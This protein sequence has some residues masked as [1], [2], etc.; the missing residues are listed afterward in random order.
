MNAPQPL[1]VRGS[2]GLHVFAAGVVT[3]Q[4]SW[5]PMALTTLVADHA[6]ITTAGLWP[7]STLLGPNLRR[8]S[9]AATAR[10]EVA[11]TIDDGPDP[12]VTPRVLDLLDTLQVRATF[13]CIGTRVLAH[14]ALAREIVQRGHA[15]ENHSHIHRHDFSLLMP[16]AYDR[17][18]G[19]AQ[20]AIAD[21]VGVAP[22]FFRAPAGLRNVF[23][24]GAL[25]RQ[26][27]TLT[28]WTRRGYDT[29][30]RDADRVA[31]R[32]VDG[33][34]AGDILLLHD[35]HAARDRAGTPVILDALPR[36]VDAIRERAL[37]PTTLRDAAR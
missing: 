18:I 13:F 1:L 15:I 21:T 34:A 3:M 26:R 37:H 32:L 36:L 9:A 11:V 28:S 33:L 16:S 7:T 14:P 29:V 35:G 23:L 27:L 25:E 19:A 4:P 31:A 24:Q 8:L 30:R 17:E 6:V 5:W 22:S 12:G 2:I 10:S 20:R